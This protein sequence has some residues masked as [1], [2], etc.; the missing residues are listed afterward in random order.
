MELER[1]A[2]WLPSG[3]RRLTEGRCYDADPRGS[4]AESLQ[5]E[6]PNEAGD[7]VGMAGAPD[8]GPSG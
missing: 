2:I 3:S 1:Y 8:C 4:K 7:V 5:L 6:R